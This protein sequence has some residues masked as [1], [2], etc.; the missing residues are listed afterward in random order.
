[1]EEAYQRIKGS[2]S[3]NPIW[4]ELEEAAAALRAVVDA[5]KKFDLN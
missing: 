4:R 1:M 3:E 2:Q 5:P